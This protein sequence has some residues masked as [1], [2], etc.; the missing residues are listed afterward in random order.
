M[1]FEDKRT[2][3][4]DEIVPDETE[5]FS[6]EAAASSIDKRKLGD[7]LR[8]G[9]KSDMFGD[10]FQKFG[11][12]SR[13]FEQMRLG[14]RS[15]SESAKIKNKKKSGGKRLPLVN[16]IHISSFSS[17]KNVYSLMR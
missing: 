12:H 15:E 17:I 10:E 1:L 4:T 6:E 2:D 3:M 16:M 14:K 11:R 13:L 8:L 7:S 5:S 9:K